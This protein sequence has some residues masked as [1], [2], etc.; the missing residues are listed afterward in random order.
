MTI[1]EISEYIHI[2]KASKVKKVSKAANSSALINNIIIKKTY[3][4]KH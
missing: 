1:N 4:I 3:S 2:T